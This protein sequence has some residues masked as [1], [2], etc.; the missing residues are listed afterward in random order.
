MGRDPKE[1][2]DAAMV[3][4]NDKKQECFASQ[5]LKAQADEDTPEG[6]PASK[7]KPTVI[8]NVMALAS[9]LSFACFLVLIV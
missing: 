4:N 9:E 5:L 2:E 1:K 3:E 7:A 6:T 8:Q